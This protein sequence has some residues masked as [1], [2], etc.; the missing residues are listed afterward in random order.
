MKRLLLSLAV[1]AVAAASC[2]KD[3]VENSND[4]KIQVIEEQTSPYAVSEEEAIKRLNNFMSAFD[5]DETRSQRRK[6]KSIKGVSF[7]NIYGNTRAN[8]PIDIENLLYIVE[9]ENGEGSAILGAD[10]RLEPVYAVLDESVLTVNDFNNAVSGENMDDIS[11]FTAGLIANRV[12]NGYIELNNS[13][14]LFPPEEELRSDW[15]DFISVVTRTKY[16]EPLLDTKWGQNSYFNDKF[17][18]TTEDAEYGDGRQSAG[19]V[20][21][22]LA[23]ILNNNSYPRPIKLNDHTYYWRDLNKH[24]WDAGDDEIDS[25]DMNLMASFIYDLAQELRVTYYSD[26]STGANTSDVKRV[27]RRSGYSNFS[28]GAISESRIYPMLQNDKS[29]WTGGF[30]DYGGHSWVIDGWKTVKTDYYCI[31]YDANNVEISREHQASITDNYVHCNMGYM[32]RCDGYYTLSAFNVS[33]GKIGD[34]VEPDC[35]DIPNSPQTISGDR[36]IYDTNLVSLT[37]NF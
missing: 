24:R 26:G 13:L 29:V 4:T 12:Y 15:Q 31:T 17:P 2:Q 37:Y 36:I 10:K 27:M 8:Q 30:S 33:N 18:T 22:A 11:T 16:I 5:G 3:F 35:G 21:I 28:E 1:I 34:S 7:N 20:T 19:C 14:T 32:G 9:F 6:V 23:Q 25:V